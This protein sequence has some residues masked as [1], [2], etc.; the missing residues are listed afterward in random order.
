MPGAEVVAVVAL[1]ALA[2]G[3]AP[4]GVVGG[5]AGRPRF[6]VPGRGPGA[7]FEAAPGGGGRVAIGEV[8]DLAARAEHVVADRED[9]AGDG[10]EER[11]GVLVVRAVAARDVTRADEHLG[12]G[13]GRDGDR[14]STYA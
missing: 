9:G 4:I 14:R 7:R 8:G 10:V 13:H 1:A 6:H 3:C 11:G 2:G 5:R 12:R